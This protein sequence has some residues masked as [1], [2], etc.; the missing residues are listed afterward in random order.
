MP[1]SLRLRRHAGIMMSKR[2]ESVASA[3]PPKMRSRGFIAVHRAALAVEG[4]VSKLLKDAAGAADCLVRVCNTGD[5]PRRPFKAAGVIGSLV[6]PR[7][8]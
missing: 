8:P 2:S 5:F 7:F 4:R 1:F 3:T 6:C